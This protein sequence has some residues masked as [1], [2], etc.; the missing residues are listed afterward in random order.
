MIMPNLAGLNYQEAQ[1]ALEEAGIYVSYPAYA[2]L[3]PA[4]ITVQWESSGPEGGL[5]V[6]Q[7]PLSGATVAQGAP[8]TLTLSTFP[9][10]AVISP[11]Y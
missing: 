6:A 1:D 4:Q 7:V 5:V 3:S 9:V 2:F 8:I 10:A 11:G